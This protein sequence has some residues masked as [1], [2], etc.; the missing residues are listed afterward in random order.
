MPLDYLSHALHVTRPVP[1]VP[2]PHAGNATTTPTASPPVKK[3]APRSAVS[4]INGSKDTSMR[5]KGRDDTY[6]V[7]RDRKVSLFL[8]YFTSFALDLHDELMFCLHRVFH[9]IST[10]FRD[11]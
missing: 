9:G 2:F 11:G 4:D 8:S 10:E 5:D 3:A 1:H 6:I 7:V